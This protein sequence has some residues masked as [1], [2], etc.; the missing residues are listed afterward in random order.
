MQKRFDLTFNLNSLDEKGYFG[1][2]IYKRVTVRNFGNPVNFFFHPVRLN[3]HWIEYLFM[4]QIFFFWL[5]KSLA[6]LNLIFFC[7]F[8]A[9]PPKTKNKNVASRI[10][11]VFMNY[12]VFLNLCNYVK[13]LCIFKIFVN[14]TTPSK[15]ILLALAAKLLNNIWSFN[16]SIFNC[17]SIFLTF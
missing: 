7:K 15:L 4:G 5:L 13:L 6:C 14:Y 11:S 17:N 8:R 1:V 10:D 16:L 2:N 3:E 9:F 12:C